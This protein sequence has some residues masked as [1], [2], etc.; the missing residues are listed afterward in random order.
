MLLACLTV[1]AQE[2][3]SE[4]ESDSTKK[5][6]KYLS[7]GSGGVK[8]GKHGDTSDKVFDVQIGMLDL[9]INYLQDKTN[10]TDPAV[11]NFLQVS[12]EMKNENLFSLR[13]GKSINV[14]IYPILLKYRALKTENHRIYVSMGLGLQM[15]NFRFNKPITYVNETTPM[16]VTDTLH[17]SKNKVGLTY[18]TVPLM[19]TMKTKL[20]KDLW[21]VYGAGV[22]AGYRIASWTKQVSHELGKQK[23]HDQF[24]FNNFN[25]C[26]TAEVG[27]EGYFRL[28]ASYQLTALHE[29]ILDQH[30]YC[31]GVRFLGI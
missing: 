8:M 1:S 2:T 15:Y 10:Y 19:V 7:I 25:S 14:N 5:N 16:V 3:E 13:E 9:G 6:G 24:N 17:F 20:A 31:I 23:N 30:P 28:Y 4:K 22:T 12:N 27:V 21:V 18:L 26:V 29:N 11:Q